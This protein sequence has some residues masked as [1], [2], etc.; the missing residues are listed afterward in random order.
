[1][2]TYTTY[3]D[4]KTIAAG[5]GSNAAGAPEVSVIQGIFDAS[6]RNLTAADV[7]E[8]LNIPANTFVHNVFYKVMTAD[9]SQTMSIGDGSSTAGYVSAADVGT[10]GNSGGSSL[11]LTEGTPNTVTGYSAG[12]F[13][14][15]EDTI[16]ILVPTGKA[17]DTL[18]VKLVATVTFVG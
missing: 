12:K 11:A 2:T 14:A 8:V 17:F 9:A 15:A 10:A 1:M 3:T 4:G 16:D 18:K 13:Y 5:S 6:K 7:A